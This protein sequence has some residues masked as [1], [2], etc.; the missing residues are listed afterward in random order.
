M[1]LEFDGVS[2]RPGRGIDVGVGHA[3]ATVVGLRYLGDNEGA[4]R[5]IGLPGQDQSSTH[6]NA[7]SVFTKRVKKLVSAFLIFITNYANYSNGF[8]YF[9]EIR[10]IRDHYLTPVVYMETRTA[11]L[12]G[13]DPFPTRIRIVS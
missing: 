4:R 2:A 8:F 5:G 10:V 12:V 7:F 11:F 3:Q 1:R 9:R 13:T 6:G